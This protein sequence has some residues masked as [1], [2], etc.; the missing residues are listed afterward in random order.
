MKLTL[1]T[2]AILG[3]AIAVSLC[4]QLLI[5]ELSKMLASPGWRRHRIAWGLMVGCELVALFDRIYHGGSGHVTA[6]VYISLFFL[7]VCGMADSY[8]L[9]LK[10]LNV[11]FRRL[12]KIG[13]NPQ[14]NQPNNV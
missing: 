10:D 11:L 3:A 13:I 12:K 9:M 7:A 6:T 4:V 5:H 2:T 14:V 8:R 1:I